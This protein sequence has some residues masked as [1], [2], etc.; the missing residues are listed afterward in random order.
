[1]A[2]DQYVFNETI[3][4]AI[5]KDDAKYDLNSEGFMD[6]LDVFNKLRLLYEDREIET[7]TTS[8]LLDETSNILNS[9]QHFNLVAQLKS[10]PD[11]IDKFLFIIL[12][13][14]TVTMIGKPLNLRNWIG[15]VFVD[16]LTELRYLQQLLKREN[17]PIKQDFIELILGNGIFDFKVIFSEKG[18]KLLLDEGII[19]V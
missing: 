8:S 9:N 4:M 3:N 19:L 2:N 6:I 14:E 17:A 12:G 16:I 15:N 18:R 10:I 7:I 1:M 13:W 5:I 11:T